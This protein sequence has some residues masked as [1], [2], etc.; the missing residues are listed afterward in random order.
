MKIFLT[1]GTGFIGSYFLRA[2]LAAG[3][4]VVALD[5]GDHKLLHDLRGEPIWLKRPMDQLRPADFLG[6][7]VAVHLAATGVSPQKAP[8]EDLFHWNVFAAVKLCAAAVEAGVPR[9]VAAGSFA[10]YGLSASRYDFIPADAPLAPVSS[11]AASKAA[12]FQGLHALS[13]ERSFQLIYARVFSVFGD[14]QHESN[15][16][17]ALKKAALSGADFPMTKGEQ[18]RDFIPVELV[19]QRLLEDACRRDAPQGQPVVYNLA[20]G[21]PTTLLA[22]AE[23]W[24]ARFNAKGRLRPGALP[25]RPN[26]VMRYVP[27]VLK[28]NPTTDGS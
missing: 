17:P 1:G 25:Y 22:F 20:S 23:Y 15:F 28:H 11:Y 10:E 2:A 24:W 18:V 7:E 12:A 3:H 21:T 16:W 8:W 27:Q 4:E 26:E 6:C 13:V 14:G 19:A 9:L 5:Y